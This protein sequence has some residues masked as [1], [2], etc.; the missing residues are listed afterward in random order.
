[1]LVGTAMTGTLTGRRRRS[2][3]SM[4]A[5]VMM[6]RACRAVDLAE[7]AV[8]AGD[9]DIV[10]P[11]GRVA[12]GLRGH[13]RFLGHGDVRRARGQDDDRAAAGRGSRLRQDHGPGRFVVRGAGELRPDTGPNGRLDP[14]DEEVRA[15]LEDLAG[16]ADDLVGRLP[17]AEDDLGSPLGHLAVVVAKSSRSRIVLRS[18]GPW[19]GVYVGPFQDLSSLLP[20]LHHIWSPTTALKRNGREAAEDGVRG[21][22]SKHGR[23]G[24]LAG[25]GTETDTSA[26][27]G[28]A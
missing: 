12:Q 24:E 10:D 22:G 1:M 3:A 17:Q 7:E 26:P 14:G 19:R 4:P 8:D 27:T 5:T 20:H 11:L 28:T 21:I 9:T 6:T 18:P 15:L 25:I 16:D 13:G 23:G 2:A